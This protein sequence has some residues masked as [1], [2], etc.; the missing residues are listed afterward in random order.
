MDR[1]DYFPKKLSTDKIR[2]DT[3]CRKDTKGIKHAYNNGCFLIL[4]LVKS[5]LGTF[6][7]LTIRLLYS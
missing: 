3:R 4:L 2:K 7:F 6:H 5:K 1:N